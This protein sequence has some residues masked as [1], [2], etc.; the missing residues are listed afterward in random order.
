MTT[1]YVST[2]IV[3]RLLGGDGRP[4]PRVDPP[5]K[6]PAVLQQSRRPS[7]EVIVLRTEP[8]PMAA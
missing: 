2:R 7:A 4:H 5:K 8:L 6:I 1:I 3:C